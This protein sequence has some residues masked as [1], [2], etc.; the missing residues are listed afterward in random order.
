V[1]TAPTLVWQT[2]RK[3]PSFFSPK[4]REKQLP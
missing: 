1:Q 2:G 3:R 4:G